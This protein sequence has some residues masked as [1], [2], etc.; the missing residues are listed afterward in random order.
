MFEPSRTLGWAQDTRDCPELTAR[1][2]EPLGPTCYFILD[3]DP[4]AFLL[5]VQGV[6]GVLGTIMGSL[7]PVE[8]ILDLD[9]LPR[10]TVHGSIEA[11]AGQTLADTCAKVRRHLGGIWPW[12]G[13]CLVDGKW[14][15]LRGQDCEMQGHSRS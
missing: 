7:A 9:D 2:V 6:A 11:L 3:A 10:A 4:A 14:K 12:V 15:S 5:Q 13:K 1:A 8:G